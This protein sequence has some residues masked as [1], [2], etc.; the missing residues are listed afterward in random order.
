MQ[1]HQDEEFVRIVLFRNDFSDA[2]AY[3][4]KS[5]EIEENFVRDALIKMGA[6]SYAKPFMKN[7]GIHNE[8]KNY[9]LP[10]SIVPEENELL[11][12][13]LMD[14]RGNFIG[15]A[16]FKTMKPSIG[17][18]EPTPKGEMIP[19]RYTDIS[20]DHWFQPSEEHPGEALLVDQV[21]EM[22]AGLIS[23]IPRALSH[24]EVFSSE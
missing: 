3:F 14:Y 21:I 20:F 9:R 18:A 6:I 10:S 8:V 19:I 7:T 23:E 12:Q 16:N 22:I 1:N 13:M 24:E 4:Q 2:I 15:H 11:H 5:K 17:E